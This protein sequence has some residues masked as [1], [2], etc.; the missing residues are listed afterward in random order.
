MNKW[1]ATIEISAEER[2]EYDLGK[3]KQAEED[4]EIDEE[5]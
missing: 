5:D 4:E 3:K 2:E 1:L